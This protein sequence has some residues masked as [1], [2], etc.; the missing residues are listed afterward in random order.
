MIK[1]L[2]WVNEKSF[3]RRY[4]VAITLSF[5][6]SVFLSS[7]HDLTAA[8]AINYPRILILYPRVLV[9]YPHPLSSILCSFILCSSILLN[10]YKSLPQ[11]FITSI[12]HS[13]QIFYER[14]FYLLLQEP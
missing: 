9:F 8:S 13:R 6:T 11:T 10:P 5:V 1:G 2:T 12:P 7:P 4:C 3:L 14:I